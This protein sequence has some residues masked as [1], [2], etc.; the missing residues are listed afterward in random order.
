MFLDPYPRPDGV[1]QAMTGATT[2]RVYIL[3]NEDAPPPSTPTGFTATVGNAQVALAWK[4]PALD[5]GVT[6]HEFRYKTTGDYPMTWTEIANSA[7]DEANEDS[8]TVPMLTNEVAHTFELR[9][10]SAGGNSDAAEAGPVTPTPGICDRTQIVHE[11]IVED[12]TGVDDCAPVTVADLAGLTSLQMGNSNI[13][14]L[15]PGDFAG[16]TSVTYLDLG[17]NSFTTLSAGVF[18]GLTALEIPPID[19]RQTEFALCR[20]VHRPVGAGKSQIGQQQTEFALCRGVL[21]PAGA[22]QAPSE[23]QRSGSRC[24]GVLRPDGADR[25]LYEQHRS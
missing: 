7:P 15:K 10:V 2:T 25:P 19:R 20:G 18:T 14:S 13:A 8:F 6:R 3:D 22:A 11:I 17:L 5:S 16:L 9:A 1:F 24:R 23:L 12:L 4:A 21:R